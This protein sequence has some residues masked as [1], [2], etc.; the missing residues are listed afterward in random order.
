MSMN[1][2]QFS[3]EPSIWAKSVDNFKIK[4]KEVWLENK[5]TIT[6]SAELL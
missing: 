2:K 5:L 3:L 4:F 6:F 1:R